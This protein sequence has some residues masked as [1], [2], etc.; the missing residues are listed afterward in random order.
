M[1]P[2]LKGICDGAG[3]VIVASEAAVARHNLTPLARIV[4]YSVVGVD[5][6]V[7]GIGPAHAVRNVLERNNLKLDQIDLVEVS[8]CVCVCVCVCLSVPSP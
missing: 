6:T 7:M 3:V 2:R 1:S 5:P 4:D 8:V